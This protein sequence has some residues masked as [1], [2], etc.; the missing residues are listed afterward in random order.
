MAIALAVGLIFVVGAIAVLAPEAHDGDASS[1][2]QPVTAVPSPKPS[3]P[4]S[5]WSHHESVSPMDKSKIVTVSLAAEGAVQGWL[6]KEVPDLIL[7]CEE[8]KTDLYVRTGMAANP[9]LGRFDEYTVRIKLDGKPAETESWSS[10]TN[11]TAL[12]SDQPIALAKR[13]ANANSLL[14]EFTPFQS[15][16]AIVTFQLNGVKHEIE[17]VANA[18]GWNLGNNTPAPARSSSTR[19]NPSTDS[20][21]SSR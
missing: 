5:K 2:A 4:L 10:S 21:A 3:A 16:R 1:H 13:L 7:R 20:S 8:K 9:E 12:F 11:N 19:P 15:N 18:C 17:S 14:F 6:Q